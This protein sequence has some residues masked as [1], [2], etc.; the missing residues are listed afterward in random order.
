MKFYSVYCKMI[1][2]VIDLGTN[3]FNLL[4]VEKINNKGYKKVTS[5]R[6]PVKLGEGAINSG[7]IA[8]IPFNRGIEALKQFSQIIK[9][10]KTEKIHAFATSAI[11]SAKNGSDFIN[12]AKSEAGIDVEVIDGNREAELIY[13]GNREAV[14]MSDDVSLIMDI[15]GGST[16]FILANSQK[17]FWKQSFLLGAARLLEK[18]NPSNPIKQTEIENLFAYFKIELQPLLEAAKNNPPTELIGSSGA[19]DSI[20]DMMAGEFH[21]E[22]LVD[23]KTEYS[24]N[25]KNYFPISQKVI[26]STSNELAQIKGLIEMRVDMIVISCLFVNFILKELKL[27]NF[28][29]STYSLKE[30]VLFNL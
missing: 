25:L 19:F 14:K 4:I 1:I 29:V 11:R 23:T 20:V 21:T 8:K 30:G 22:S 24:I 18:I 12:K 7:Y 13:F 3:T 16:E 15:G 28:R 27:S 6:V 26:H 17:I 9:S 10:N 5:N 2:A